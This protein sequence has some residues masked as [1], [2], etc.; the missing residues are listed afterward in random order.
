MIKVGIY[1]S[2]G[3]M[4]QVVLKNVLDDEQT[5]VVALHAI[6]E[7]PFDAPKGVLVT[8]DVEEFLK[9]VDV[10]ID[11]SL[12]KGTESLLEALISKVQ[13]P[14]VCAVTGLSA[15][16]ENLLFEASKVT[17]ILHATNMSL[18][19][20]ILNKLTTLASKTLDDFDCEIVEQHHRYKKDAPSGTALTLATN[21]AK[22]RGLDIDKVRVSGRNG[23][24]GERT[25]EE[26]GV[27]SIRGGDV[28]GRHTVGFYNDGEY[29]E[30][31][32]QATSRDT[33]AKG[34]IKAA[35]WL[36][37]QQSGL[38]GIDDCLGI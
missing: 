18:G 27:M 32:H 22:A 23:D 14:L 34:S 38:Y 4:G 12:P 21:A 16:Q 7:L 6:E 33:F 25:K 26:I 36:V 20:A 13:K 3:R 30:L 8:N 5:E 19:V 37:E 17:P 24:I 29:V 9:S 31:Y 28:V 35:K 11:F 15:H 10:V 2:T 1:G